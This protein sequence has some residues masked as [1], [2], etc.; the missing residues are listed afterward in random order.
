MIHTLGV[1]GLVQRFNA[2]ERLRA[3]SD[4]VLRDRSMLLSIAQRMASD[5]SG[6]FH[7][8]GV[9][10]AA[11]AARGVALTVIQALG[12]KVAS[13]VAPEPDRVISL[14]RGVR[15]AVASL[16]EALDTPTH[17]GASEGSAGSLSARRR[18]R[19]QVLE[20]WGRNL[21]SVVFPILVKCIP[22]L[23]QAVKGLISQSEVR[24]VLLFSLCSLLDS[25]VG[26]METCLSTARSGVTYDARKD[27]LDTVK[28]IGSVLRGDALGAALLSYAVQAVLHLRLDA[29]SAKKLRRAQQLRYGKGFVELIKQVQAKDIKATIAAAQALQKVH[30]EVEALKQRPWFRRLH[31]L[32]DAEPQ[33]VIRAATKGWARRPPRGPADEPFPRFDGSQR[34]RL[35]LLELVDAIA[36]TPPPCGLTPDG[37]VQAASENNAER[38]EW[39]D[40][41]CGAIN[42]M[43][44]VFSRASACGTDGASQD[45]MRTSIARK[46]YRLCT[47]PIAAVRSCARDAYIQIGDVRDPDRSCTGAIVKAMACCLSPV[48]GPPELEEMRHS[49]DLPSVESL[50][51]LEPNVLFYRHFT[52]GVNTMRVTTKAGGST[53]LQDAFAATCP[54][55]AGIERLRVASGC[56]ELPQDSQ[57]AAP[58]G[59]Q[60][61]G[62]LSSPADNRGAHERGWVFVE[63]RCSDTPNSSS[64]AP[65]FERLGAW[66]AQPASE[67]RVCL[68]H[69]YS[70]SGK[71]AT[72]ERLVRQL[73]SK[74]RRHDPTAFVPV[75]CHLGEV[76]NPATHAVAHAFQ[77]LAKLDL[78]STLS[79]SSSPTWVIVLQGF[80]EVRGTTNFVTGNRIATLL[81]RAKVIVTCRTH[82]L[83]VLGN[84]THLFNAPMAPLELFLR[85]FS[86]AQINRFVDV[87]VGQHGHRP[88]ATHADP[89]H[90]S[91]VGVGAG[92][93]IGAG[94]GAQLLA[95]GHVTVDVHVLASGDDS[96]ALSGCIWRPVDFKRAFSTIPGLLELARTPF[97][98]RLLVRAL[99]R[100][101]PGP[102]ET[103][104]AALQAGMITRRD[105]FDCFV[106]R[107]FHEQALHLQ[108][109][110]PG[111][112][113]SDFDVA[114]SLRDYTEEFAAELLCADLQLVEPL[115]NNYHSRVDR[116]ARGQLHWEGR[117]QRFFDTSSP[118]ASVCLQY[119]PLRK[120]G[121]GYVLARCEL[122]A[123]V[124]NI[125]ACGS[126]RF[127][128]KSLAEYFASSLLLRELEVCVQR[129][130]LQ[131]DLA[132]LAL[133]RVDLARN[134]SVL[135]FMVDGLQRRLAG[136][137]MQDWVSVLSRHVHMKT[138]L[139]SSGVPA[140]PVPPKLAQLSS[141]CATLLVQSGLSL[142]GQQMQGAWLQGAD[143]S[144]AV[145]ASTNLAGANLAN[146]CLHRAH[147]DNT[148]LTGANLRGA[149]LGVASERF[150]AR[151]RRD[152]L[153][154][155]AAGLM[156]CDGATVSVFQGG[157]CQP[158]QTGER[159]VNL[160][161]TSTADGNVSAAR[162]QLTCDG[163]CFDVSPW[164]RDAPGAQ[165]RQGHVWLAVAAANACK[166]LL[167]SR[168]TTQEDVSDADSVVG[169]LSLSAG[170]DISS[171]ALSYGGG[172][173]AVA[174]ASGVFV[175]ARKA[176]SVDGSMS[177]FSGPHRL[178][179]PQPTPVNSVALAS[180]GTYI[181]GCECWSSDDAEVTRNPV[182]VVWSRG[183]DAHFAA[184]AQVLKLSFVPVAL[185]ASSTQ[186]SVAVGSAE[187]MVQL[188]TRQGGNWD[189]HD[190]HDADGGICSL[191][192]STSGRYLIAGT[193]ESL[194]LV[195]DTSRDRCPHVTS[196]AAPERRL[197]AVA[198]GTHLRHV[199]VGISTGSVLAVPF[200]STAV[201]TASA[202][203]AGHASAVTSV[204]FGCGDESS[205][206][207]Q[208]AS[209]LASCGS[210]QTVRLW[211]TVF[212]QTHLWQTRGKCHGVAA[213]PRGLFAGGRWVQLL[214]CAT[215]AGL[216]MWGMNATGWTPLVVSSVGV[217][218]VA[219]T[220][221]A[222]AASSE[223]S[224]TGVAFSNDCKWLAAHSASTV[225]VWRLDVPVVGSERGLGEAE[226]ASGEGQ[227]TEACDAPF[228]LVAKH[229]A[230]QP[231]CLS[232]C[233]GT[234]LGIAG[235]GAASGSGFVSATGYS[236]LDTLLVGTASGQ[237]VEVGLVGAAP[238]C[239]NWDLRHSA[240]R[241]A[242]VDGAVACIASSRCGTM[243]AV[244]GHGGASV[245][246]CRRGAD[247]SRWE[248]QPE[249]FEAQ[250]VP[251]SLAFTP[252]GGV[253][254]C[255]ADGS[256]DLFSSD[257]LALVHSF[258]DVGPMAT[259]VAVSSRGR[260]IA[261]AS[262]NC[263][264]HVWVHCE[265][266][267]APPYRLHSILAKPFIRSFHASGVVLDASGG[268]SE[269]ERG[270]SPRHAAMLMN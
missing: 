22:K 74:Y 181:I 101:V 151:C 67:S 157:S 94:A 10:L 208:S 184:A 252:H 134:A 196:I 111:S 245:R 1:S 192:F 23:A 13:M 20:Q 209:W 49:I 107:W 48:V 92:A 61:L 201:A 21:L 18:T 185:A 137:N 42:A 36:R 226:L 140:P 54:V 119:S 162:K 267:G 71:N 179:M 86:E 31:L 69:G 268:G 198:F 218:P 130:L 178:A 250:D 240:C 79:S 204:C 105:L 147:L 265:V 37:R 223:L 123:R 182:L 211:S 41:V 155:T 258:G 85:P 81:P 26:C 80:D 167:V 154:D 102:A 47:S 197:S 51:H 227:P 87:V 193:T 32:F 239:E 205:E 168:N 170:D 135:Q 6:S 45:R 215:S 191:N 177:D 70:G 5:F 189:C 224:V 88:A 159:K 212:T 219:R 114:G 221:V 43:V 109:N 171:V 112:L 40:N 232:F 103:A 180:N 118:I 225:F 194:A 4:D 127:I 133:N 210:D 129:R 128:H 38:K 165:H 29:N 200:D 247:G 104:I 62:A 249:G 7:D 142:A 46:L 160:G 161:V 117:W 202:T 148:V 173:V 138:V 116:L 126:Y 144:G 34:E 228:A 56:D 238:G 19:D 222:A 35:L 152:G 156:V 17:G 53:L 172:A 63:P 255:A 254:V 263:K 64:G 131:H 230:I 190:L 60:V 158:L 233:R 243:F 97:M 176:S 195:W 99:P 113:P 199:Y 122:E 187:G 57:A 235:V 145:L 143:L 150:A 98:L 166:V 89:Q 141:N 216:H 24:T 15:F 175:W 217:A 11:I 84:T 146:V 83:Q 39:L 229:S 100:M 203:N 76:P 50:Q 120:S 78:S 260:A 257:T 164:V 132:E 33:A 244:A 25:A 214:A 72:V 77:S 242:P 110:P 270:V 207:T 90:V 108:R 124:A 231:T 220:P 3:H 236:A 246:L 206:S 16:S 14:A 149:D 261:A 139:S 121:R 262:L 241:A 8:D 12:K 153:H 163:N 269:S 125:T 58:R 9:A 91:G 75:V 30:K 259:C 2:S 55:E 93:G 96:Q 44:A 183:G 213:S 27:I 52:L 266:S 136:P 237:V 106:D 264:V 66:L 95:D 253:V 82:Y 169:I 174:A 234:G 28:G 73:W 186:P 248:R 65:L 251:T 256:V 188:W 68:L 59:E 115:A